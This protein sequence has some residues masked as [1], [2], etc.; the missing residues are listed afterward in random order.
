MRKKFITFLLS[1]A[2]LLVAGVHAAA[3]SG[4]TATVSSM[5]LMLDGVEVKPAGYVIDDYTY[6]KLRD[7]AYFMRDKLCSFSVNYD[8][9]ARSIA[10][11]TGDDY[12]EDGTELSGVDG[13]P[14][15]AVASELTVQVDGQPVSM[16]SYNIDGYTYYKLR[17]I[18][19]HLG[20]TVDYDSAT[21]T[22]SIHSPGYTEPEP[23]Q[24]PERNNLDGMVTIMLD[25]GH[26]GGDPGASSKDGQYDENHLNLS[27]AL[28]LK[29]LLEQYGA[30]I[31]MTRSDTQT[32]PS[33]QDRV[34][35]VAANRDKLDFFLCIHHNSGGGTGSEV[36]VPSDQQDPS[37]ASRE[38][39]RLILAEYEK[40]G[41][42]N[43]G[44]KDGS[45]MFVVRG[46]LEQGVPGL[47][48]EFCFL[49][50]ADLEKIATEQGQQAEA[51]A[52]FNA[53]QQYFASHAY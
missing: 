18:G 16:Q 5:Q 51:Q 43:R 26:G 2:I 30:T 7:I 9:A 23:P 4:K 25:P 27:V 44:L 21:K 48:S 45:G 19:D 38:M 53:V 29:Q 36:L 32:F 33:L 8:A 11:V 3:A 40:L 13:R 35:M 42:K 47:L 6:F 41:L 52:I 17:D 39:A 37:G 34:D 20:F 15:Q 31:L 22:G 46:S 24:L 1:A 49:D 50:T 28:R 12:E 10:L 14:K